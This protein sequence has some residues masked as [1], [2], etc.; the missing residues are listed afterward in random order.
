MH[1][2][3]VGGATKLAAERVPES[4]IKKGSRSSLDAFMVYVRATMEDP[5]YV[6]EVLWDEARERE[7]QPVQ[8]TR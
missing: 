6:P 8:L 2:G 7:R 1:S 4:V 3:R 5:V